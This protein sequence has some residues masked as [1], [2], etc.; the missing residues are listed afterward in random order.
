MPHEREIIFQVEMPDGTLYGPF[1]GDV[2]KAIWRAGDIATANVED[3]LSVKV[4]LV[5]PESLGYRKPRRLM[6]RVWVNKVA[7]D[8]LRYG[9]MPPR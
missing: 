5:L 4:W 7:G 1:R 8:L 2:L 9:M 3:T 6:A